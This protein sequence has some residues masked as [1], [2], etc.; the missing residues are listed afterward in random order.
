MRRP[1]NSLRFALW[2]SVAPVLLLAAIWLPGCSPE[3][4]LEPLDKSEHAIE[5]NRVRWAE[6]DPWAG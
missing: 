3:P 4:A 1:T 5:S 6:E 2:L